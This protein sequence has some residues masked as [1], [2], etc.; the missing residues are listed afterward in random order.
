MS[1]EVRELTKK[2]MEAMKGYNLGDRFEALSC[3]MASG[4]VATAEGEKE[5]LAMFGTLVTDLVEKIAKVNKTMDMLNEEE[6]E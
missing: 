2:I 6:N 3:V 5:Q 1:K 4:I